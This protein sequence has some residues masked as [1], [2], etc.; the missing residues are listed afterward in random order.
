[1]MRWCSTSTV[2]PRPS[3]APE[4]A[5]RWCPAPSTYSRN[6][7]PPPPPHWH[8]TGLDGT[9]TELIRESRNRD[10]GTPLLPPTRRRNAR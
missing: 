2:G 3:C 7:E 4:A 8:L 9:G 1:M 10:T 5:W 6:Q